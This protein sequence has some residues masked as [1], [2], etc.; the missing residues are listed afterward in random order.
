MNQQNCSLSSHDIWVSRSNTNLHLFLL[1]RLENKTKKLHRYA[2]L[3]KKESRAGN[4]KIPPRT[5]D[6]LSRNPGSSG[7]VTRRRSASNTSLI[8]RRSNSRAVMT[9]AILLGLRRIRRVRSTKVA[10]VGTCIGLVGVFVDLGVW[11]LGKHGLGCLVVHAAH[12]DICVLLAQS[13]ALTPAGHGRESVFIKGFVGGG[14]VK[15]SVLWLLGAVDGGSGRLVLGVL[16]KL[17]DWGWWLGVSLVAVVAVPTARGATG[18]TRHAAAAALD[19]AAETSHQTPHDGN[20]YHH[21]DDDADDY[22]PPGEGASQR[23]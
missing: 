10:A 6:R 23:L 11:R 1:E 19:A 15:M 14:S 4:S 8:A 5:T 13:A 2:M 22:W 20:G 9:V 7:M 12:L 17:R 21:S 3:T 18:E 16:R